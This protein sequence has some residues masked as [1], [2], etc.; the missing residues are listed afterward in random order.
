MSEEP[1]PPRAAD[2]V[3]SAGGAFAAQGTGRPLVVRFGAMGDMIQSTALLAGL[4]ERWGAPCDVVAGAGSAP[5]RVLA[6]LPFVGEVRTL[7]SR[8]TPYLLSAEQR[9]LVAWLLG[10]SA[11]PVY[12]VEELPKVLRLL[13]RGG[14][15]ADHVLS[16][17]DLPRGDLE[18]ALAYQHRLLA[19]VPS[20]FADA[21]PPAPAD[22]APRPRLA[23]TPEERD[24]CLAW[25]AR[26]GWQGEPLVV[27][28]TQSRRTKRGRWPVERWV[29]LT[30]GVRRELPAA[31]VL[32][33]GSPAEEAAV[34]AL[35]AAAGDR[36]VEAAADLPLRRLF[37]LFTLAH[38]C[39][40][41]DTGPSHAAAAL[42][43]PLVVLFGMADPRRN[44]PVAPPGFAPIVTAVP[45]ERWP[46]SR[47]AWEAWH[48]VAEIP[49]EPV[50]AAWRALPRRRPPEPAPPG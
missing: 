16:M 17:R 18:H 37:A 20:A 45:E 23:T 9:D 42:G 6:H 47:A 29:E 49:A 30:R 10:R 36:Q 14:V 28:Q 19:A 35:A 7:A 34:A 11:G 48:D 26:R 24:D 44:R 8:R 4:A 25:L 39:V 13:A 40:S 15:E 27:L 50:I 33:A 1:E 12:A 43:C 5:R 31:R 32:L 3:S 21:P 46:P 38:S 2:P 41:L 22:P